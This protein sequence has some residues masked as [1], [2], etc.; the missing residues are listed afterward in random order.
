MLFAPIDYSLAQ[1]PAAIYFDP[2][3]GNSDVGQKVIVSLTVD[4]NGSNYDS[5]FISIDFPADILEVQSFSLGPSFT[6]SSPDNGFDNSKGTLSYGAGIPG[7][8]DQKT[9]FGTIVFNTKKD[10][11]AKISLN[12]ESMVLQNGEDVFSGA[13]A[14]AAFSIYPVQA[15]PTNS[16]PPAS[17]PLPAATKQQ[18]ASEIGA[19]TSP[20]PE[21]TSAA[22]EKVQIANVAPAGVSNP[23]KGGV[24]F[25]NI[26][27]WWWIILPVIFAFFLLWLFSGKEENKGY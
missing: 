9:V 12:S 6:S 11:T 14:V 21:Q 3:K 25:W 10:G 17:T 16:P 22:E 5:A 24:D 26:I 23:A 27:K 15:V 7:G 18:A 20:M 2:I 13:P 4:P 1:G 19:K 8:T